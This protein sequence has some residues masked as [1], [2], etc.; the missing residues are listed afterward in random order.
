MCINCTS[1]YDTH[2]RLRQKINVLV[3]RGAAR[4]IIFNN[5][6]CFLQQMS[7][8]AINLVGGLGIFSILHLQT[9][10]NRPSGTEHC[11]CF[12]TWILLYYILHYDIT[13]KFL[14]PLRNV[15]LNVKTWFLEMFPPN[16]FPYV[17]FLHRFNIL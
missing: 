2:P 15:S 17:V 12:T 14:S 8:S 1:Q 16:G 11:H 3:N 5:N 4:T 9:P 10:G 13:W 7:H 6:I